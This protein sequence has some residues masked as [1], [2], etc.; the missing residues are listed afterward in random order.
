ML[1]PGIGNLAIGLECFS[2]HAT[3]QV[4][5][6]YMY[7]LKIKK[8]L[9]ITYVLLPVFQ[10]GLLFSYIFGLSKRH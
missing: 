3:W 10:L 7:S 8:K 6:T 2:F 4:E 5:D 1:Q 9:T